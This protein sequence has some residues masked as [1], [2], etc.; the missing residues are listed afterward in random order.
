MRRRLGVGVAAAAAL[1]VTACLPPGTVDTGF[2]GADGAEVPCPRIGAV[3]GIA[4]GGTV[5]AC[6]VPESSGNDTG[7]DTRVVV[8]GPNGQPDPTFG[9]DGWVDVADSSG[10][11][12]GVAQAGDG[13]IIVVTSLG[14][15]GPSIHRFRSDGSVETGF[16]GPA[17]RFSPATVGFVRI[18]NAQ[19]VIAFHGGDLTVLV[20]QESS[21]CSGCGIV[22]GLRVRAYLGTG[23]V[24]AAQIG[25][26]QF[27]DPVPPG[28]TEARLLFDPISAAFDAQDRLVIS[29]IVSTTF[30]ADG[31]FQGTGFDVGAVRLLSGGILDTT[32]GTDG[33]ARIDVGFDAAGT[34]G[35]GVGP[36][37][38]LRSEVTAG[39]VTFIASSDP[40]P[41]DTASVAIG[42]IGPDGDL[43]TDFG[44]GGLTPVAFDGLAGV[45]QLAVDV[46]GRAIIVG[47]DGIGEPLLARRYLA[48]GTP[49]LSYGTG[50]ATALPLGPGQNL[51]SVFERYRSDSFVGLTDEDGARLVRLTS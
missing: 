29:G 44:D 4:G 38:Y 18:P 42:R 23:E 9:G 43:D 15:G 41:G 13:D 30:L 24:A 39:S 27:M 36:G 19:S 31:T 32:Y 46:F 22:D 37:N 17:T 16:G 50:G 6:A 48:D 28:A 14:L 1:L 21:T 11:T 49:D 51:V 10:S 7:F 20:T 33:L 47:R 3:A 26:N 45:P 34:P 5:L 25:L 2:G 40:A 35:I 8:L 12:Y